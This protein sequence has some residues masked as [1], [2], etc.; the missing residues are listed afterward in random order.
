MRSLLALSD[1]LD[2][3]GSF[4]GR[5]GSWAILPMVGITVFDV[6]T[7]KYPSVNTF[8]IEA[9]NHY[10]T[11]TKLQEMEWHLHTLLF[12]LCLGWG[13]LRDSHVRVDLVREKLPFMTQQWI[14]FLGCTLFLMPYLIVITYFGFDFVSSSFATMEGSAAM[15]GLPYRYIIKGILVFGL[16]LGISAGLAV[17]LRKFVILF[18]NSEYREEALTFASERQGA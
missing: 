10:I 12:S 11:S 2:R 16:I 18:G 17:W 9:S 6:I 4:F 14:E 3:I 1:V 7:R 8:I 13:Y 15:T 5:Y